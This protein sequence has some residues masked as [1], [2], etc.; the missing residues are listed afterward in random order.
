MVKMTEDINSVHGGVREPWDNDRNVEL[1]DQFQSG[2][3]ITA[4]HNLNSQK[5][6]TF[7]RRLMNFGESHSGKAKHWLNQ[8]Q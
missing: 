5:S 6:Q 1:N 8:C 3:P 7:S 4:F 2:S